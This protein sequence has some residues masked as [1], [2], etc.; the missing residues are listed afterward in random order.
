M[1]TTHKI[2]LALQPLLLIL[3]ANDLS[4]S[5]PKH[6]VPWIDYDGIEAAAAEAVAAEHARMSSH[7][8][9]SKPPHK[10]HVPKCK[11]IS[12]RKEWRQLKRSEKK[13][14]LKAVKCLT[15]KPDYGISPVSDK[16]VLPLVNEKINILIR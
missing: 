14:Y 10:G 2:I 1:R 15:K 9:H 8:G 13:E 16:W 12:K 3:A 6:L 4:H 7:N 11:K 5:N